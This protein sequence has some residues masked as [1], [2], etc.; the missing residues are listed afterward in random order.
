MLP[1][2]WHPDGEALVPASAQDP[3]STRIFG[4]IPGEDARVRALGAGKQQRYAHWRSADLPSPDRIQ[5]ACP[6]Y[7]S[8]GGC[9]W[10]HL[11]AT[12]AAT[13]KVG[14]LRAA[15]VKEGLD[16]PIEALR[17]ADREGYRHLLKLQVGH[18]G[19]LGAYGRHSHTVQE[20]PHC[21][22]LAPALRPLLRLPEAPVSMR[23]M[24]AR[25]SSTNGKVMLTVVSRERTKDVQQY[26]SL[27]QEDSVVF[28]QN[29]KDGDGLF[30][31]S[32][33]FVPLRG[34]PWI[35]EQ[36]GRAKIRV[37]P[38]E[39]YQTYPAMAR[40]LWE[41]LPLPQGKLVDLYCGVGAVSLALWGRSRE[42]LE[43]F[44]VEEGEAAVRRATQNAQL[45]GVEAS[46][47]AQK[48]AEATVPATYAE[49]MVVVNPP[50]KGLEVGVVQKLIHL[51]PQP[52]VYISCN[53]AA[54]ARDL[55]LLLA[56]G[57]K[58]RSLRP[59]DM[60]PQ[61]PHLETVAVLE[62]A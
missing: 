57:M 21:K 23:V 27:L 28:H 56:G 45:N 52:L 12:A 37:G 26:A 46:F 7:W 62:Q 35:E 48:M 60:F 59:Y 11:N 4:G 25:L 16:L 22:V 34:D 58:L 51:R 44:G 40:R 42:K 6:H 18:D 49:S 55:R 29:Q 43:I 19:S 53:P 3:L 5:P 14:A 32:R 47:V 2:A 1:T 50:R 15:L 8:C 17:E 9:P 54:L 36:V 20:I 31:Y 10:M 13:A 38:G 24:V 30:D 41:E 61:T 33:P 39:F